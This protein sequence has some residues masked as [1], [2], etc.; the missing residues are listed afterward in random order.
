MG[1]K[2][3]VGKESGIFVNYSQSQFNIDGYYDINGINGLFSDF[4]LSQIDLDSDTDPEFNI[5]SGYKREFLPYLTMGGGFNF[6]FVL[7]E[8]DNLSPDEVDLFFG[9]AFGPITSVLFYGDDVDYLFILD[10]NY[11]PLNFIPAEI[12][13]QSYIEQNTYDLRLNVSKQIKNS[14]NFGY[15]L[16]NEKYFNVEEKLYIKNGIS[17]PLNVYKEKRGFFHEIYLGYQF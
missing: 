5:T 13:F 9:L 4:W 6:Y 1:L 11:G 10:L 2:A 12:T 15:I 7:A 16:S 3:K 14:F 17:N 8:K